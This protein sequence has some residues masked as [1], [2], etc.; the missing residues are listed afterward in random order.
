[1]LAQHVLRD[2]ERLEGGTPFV[3]GRPSHEVRL[4]LLDKVDHR[5]CPICG[6]K[7]GDDVEAP[8]LRPPLANDKFDE[9]RGGPPLKYAHLLLH[10]EN[11]VDQSE[12]RLAVKLGNGR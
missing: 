12:K 11:T 7:H 3:L 9:R 10:R 5:R 1:M 4:I 8:R 2:L 6:P